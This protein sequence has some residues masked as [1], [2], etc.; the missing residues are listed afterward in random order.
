MGFIT[1]FSLVGLHGLSSG[2][3]VVCAN[4]IG[5]FFSMWLLLEFHEHNL[6]TLLRNGLA[7]KLNCNFR[8][9]P[10]FTF[11]IIED[12][13]GVA[14]LLGKSFLE[15]FL[16]DLHWKLFI[17]FWIWCWWWLL[18]LLL[19]LDGNFMCGLGLSKFNFLIF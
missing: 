10:V 3:S 19:L 6:K 16:E 13:T 9:F 15:H 17:I 4:L 7:D 11:E 2:K 5:F 14:V 12:R 8:I 18:S 1:I